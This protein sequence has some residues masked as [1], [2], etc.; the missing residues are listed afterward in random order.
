MLAC[1]CGDDPAGANQICGNGTRPLYYGK[2]AL[3]PQSGI[4]TQDGVVKKSHKL[5]GGAIAGIVIGCWVFLVLCTAAAYYIV[6]RHATMK[7]S[8]NL[9]ISP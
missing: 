1:E 4:T 8:M 6:K 2:T 5:S 9:S 3:N 7:A